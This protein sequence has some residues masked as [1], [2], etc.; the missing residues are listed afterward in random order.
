MSSSPLPFM[1]ATLE[2]VRKMLM[3]EPRVLI[4]KKIKNIAKKQRKASTCI[5]SARINMYTQNE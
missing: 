4:T 1:S 5:I 2:K 3:K